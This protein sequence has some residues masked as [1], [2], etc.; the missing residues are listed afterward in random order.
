MWATRSIG[1]SVDARF[2]GDDARDAEVA[3]KMVRI[4]TELKMQAE[5]RGASLAR[6]YVTFT[7]PFF[8]ELRRHRIAGVL[9]TEFFRDYPDHSDHFHA[10]FYVP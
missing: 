6:I 7:S 8:E 3:R 5:A 2:S 1:A 4:A 9:A 10:E